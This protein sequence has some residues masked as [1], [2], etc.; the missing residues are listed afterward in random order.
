MKH[1]EALIQTL[2]SGHAFVEHDAGAAEALRVRVL[3]RVRRESPLALKDPRRHE[4]YLRTVAHLESDARPD[5]IESV[6]QD[7]LGYGPLQRFIY[8]D[9]EEDRGITEVMVTGYNLVYVERHGVME[10]STV[11]FRDEDHLC[12]VIQ[13][14]IMSCGRRIDESCPEQDAQLPDGSRVNA[15]IPPIAAKGATMTVRR[16]PDPL[17]VADLVACGAL[18]PEAAAF[19]RR[20]VAEGLNVVVTGGMGS[21]KT[22]VLNALTD[23][24]TEAHGPAASLVVFE[25]VL[26]LQ[27]RHKNTRHFLSRP[28][29]LDGTGGIS[30]SDLSRKMLMRLR[31]NFIVLGECRG[32][33]AY[34]VVTAMCMGH[35]AMTTFHAI[36]AADAVLRRFP[37]MIVMSDEGKAEGRL[38]ALERVATAVDVVVHCAKVTAGGKSERRVV[39]VA[40]VLSK[41][42]SDGQVPDPRTLFQFRDGRLEQVASPKV[43]AKKKLLF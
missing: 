31:P 36:D 29:G 2:L 21:G 30:L 17:A 8:P 27:P 9:R 4:G 33:E 25:D 41:E 37:G 24:I 38:A 35:P 32:R 22:T 16:F 39:Q 40:E 5:L 14:I 19:L 42:T 1:E 15:A 12:S 10:E 6:V 43:F 28:P 20:T 7:I 26:E 3:D 18:T 13:K 23:F 11:R 34:D